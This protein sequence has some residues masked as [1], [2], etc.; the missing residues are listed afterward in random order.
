MDAP[1]DLALSLGS[2]F[3]YDR[4]MRKP[5]T[6]K[7]K[8]SGR[9]ATGHGPAISIHLPASLIASID[10]W[11]SEEGADSR[12]E[13]IRRL[14]EAGLEGEQRA[15]RPSKRAAAKA[16]E[17]AGREI[18]RVS[19]Q[20]ATAEERESRKRRLLKGPREFRDVRVPKRK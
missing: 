15:R 13:A 5:M 1:R 9:A 17:L 10:V 18:D 6:A 12:S 3:A 19:D 2:S 14:V 7:R 20:A 4:F 11:A 8:G 16:T